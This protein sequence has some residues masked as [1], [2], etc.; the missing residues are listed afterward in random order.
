MGDPS[1][2]AVVVG[3]SEPL[4]LLTSAAPDSCLSAGGGDDCGAVVEVAAAVAP[5]VADVWLAV[6]EYTDR[7]ERG[8]GCSE[9]RRFPTL[10]VLRVVLAPFLVLADVIVGED[11][12][13]T[14]AASEEVA[15]TDNGT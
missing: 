10:R 7:A 5:A 2:P 4:R 12:G 6:S 8:D 1:R 15:E 13:C 11:L 3:M 9:R 14:P